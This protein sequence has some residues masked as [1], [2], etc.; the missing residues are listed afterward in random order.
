[1]R[2]T[3]DTLRLFVAAYP[4]PDVAEAWSS[5]I[6]AFGLPEDRLIPAE[7]M[8]MTL[9]F[10]GDKPVKALRD[11]RESVERAAKG[12][13]PTEL[14]ADRLVTIPD[15]GPPALIALT[16]QLTGPLR[17]LQKRLASRLARPTEKRRREFSP[18]VTL[19]RFA[20]REPGMTIAAAADEWPGFGLTDVRLMSSRLLPGGAVHEELAR[21]PLLD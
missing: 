14:Q 18:H 5:R 17:E 15:R 19:C 13:T 2:R 20:P 21:V 9:V 11:V 7:Q 1:M 4:P 6:S 3:G 10:I 12:I 8:H 16:F